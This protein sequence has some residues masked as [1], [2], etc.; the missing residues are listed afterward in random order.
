MLMDFIYLEETFESGSTLCKSLLFITVV[1]SLLAQESS[2]GK[3]TPPRG[4]N[5][6]HDFIWS[7]LPLSF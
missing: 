2:Y 1:L 4:R 7:V 5:G 6:V 3:A